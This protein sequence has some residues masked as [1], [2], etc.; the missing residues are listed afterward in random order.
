MKLINFFFLICFSISVFGQNKEFQNTADDARAMKIANELVEK[1]TI[2][3]KVSLCHKGSTME[4]V[5]AIPRLGIPE[6]RF[7]GATNAIYPDVKPDNYFAFLRP[8]TDTI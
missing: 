8:S 5:D 1:M 4:A 6:F 2:E 3:E 7:C